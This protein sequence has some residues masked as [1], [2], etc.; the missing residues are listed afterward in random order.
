MCCA[1]SPMT[2][3]EPTILVVT[4]DGNKLGQHM[5]ISDSMIF[6][7]EVVIVKGNPLLAMRQIVRQ[8]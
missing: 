2:V 3:I 7:V 6:F 1:G 8:R 4:R 5:T